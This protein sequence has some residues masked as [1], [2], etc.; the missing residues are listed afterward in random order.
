[1]WCAADNHNYNVPK[2]HILT[3][4]NDECNV[5]N[6]RLILGMFPDVPAFKVYK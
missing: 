4:Q 1:M 5:K 6:R 3:R 2:F